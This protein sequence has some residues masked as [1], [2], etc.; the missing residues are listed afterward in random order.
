MKKKL[1]RL[2]CALLV[3]TMVLAM[4]P[5]VSAADKE[6]DKTVTLLSTFDVSISGCTSRSHTDSK[7]PAKDYTYTIDGVAYDD[8][9]VAKTDYLKRTSV[10]GTKS[11]WKVQAVNT[12]DVSGED[13]VK[14]V[15]TCP[16]CNKTATYNITVKYAAI[17][18]MSIDTTK[19]TLTVTKGK[20]ELPKGVSK[21]VKIKLLDAASRGSED[22]VNPT[23]YWISTNPGAV[24]V[25][26]DEKGGT[27]SQTA[28]LTVAEDAEAGSVSTIIATAAGDESKSVSFE[29]TVTDN[30][31]TLTLDK[32]ELSLDIGKTTKVGY[33]MGGPAKTSSCYVVWRYV[34]PDD[35]KEK[36]QDN[37]T[38]SILTLDNT[39]N[40]AVPNGKTDGSFTTKKNGTFYLLAQAFTP[41]REMHSNVQFCRV[42][43]RDGSYSVEIK[44]TKALPTGGSTSQWG[45]NAN[46]SAG[47]YNPD[48]EN[49]KFY[50]AEEYK[51]KDRLTL[52]TWLMSDSASA[53][54]KINATW[55]V[56]DSDVVAF[57]NYD[58]AIRTKTVSKVKDTDTVTIRAMG[59][60]KTTVKAET[61]EGTATFTIEVWDKTMILVPGTT[62]YDYT[63]ELT[64]SSENPIASMQSK[65]PTHPVTE[66][67][68]SGTRVISVPVE[69]FS[70]EID[71]KK[72]TVTFTGELKLEKNENY[73]VYQVV[74]NR[75]NVVTN[76]NVTVKAITKISDNASSIKIKTQPKS[77]TYKVG[78]TISDLKIVAEGGSSLTYQWYDGDTNKAISGATKSTY[79]PSINKSGTYK[80]YC[81]VSS[82]SEYV[83]SETATIK[84]SGEY[85][86]VLSNSSDKTVS[87]P[88][89]N[90]GSGT[91]Y[92]VDVQKWD[93]DSGKYGSAGSCSVSWAVSKN[94]ELG[95]V[96]S[97]SSSVTF[98]GKLAKAATKGFATMTVTATIKKSGT[99]VGTDEIEVTINPAEAATVKQSVGSGAALKSSSITSAV[100][101]AAG[102][103]AKI[104][105]VVFG[106]PKGCKL[107]KSSSSSTSIGDTKCYVSTTSGQKLSDVYVKTTASSASVTYT[108]YD[109]DDYALASGTVSFDANDSNDTISSSGASFKNAAAVDQIIEEYPEAEYVKLDLPRA[110]EGKLYY[111]F[112]TI[113]DFASEVKDSDK[114]YVNASSSQADVEDVYFLPVYGVKGKITI[115]YT[116]YGS[117][118]S[119]LGTGKITL[120]V[121]SKTASSKFTDVTAS[122][123]GSWA[124]D[125]IDFCADN[126]L[127]NGKST[128]SFAPKD[129]LTRGQLVAIL[130]RAAG[131]PSVT[132]T[133]NPFNDVKTG[134]YYYNAVLW[135][136]KNDV[137]NG[138]GAGKFSPNANVTREQIAAILY[139]YMGSP[140][141]T[142]SL[143]GYS[144]RS[145]I[146]S[147]ATTAMQ[148]AIGKGYITGTSS[149]T[150]DPLGQ[151]TRAQ[152][153]VMLHRFLTK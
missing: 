134:D 106:S 102:S 47:V 136:Y 95:S 89:A 119:D 148:W 3:M 152:A 31:L 2:L 43:V 88:S 96:S 74:D 32:E 111:D 122:N 109:A 147:W 77:E 49:D 38:A 10:R 44:P 30:N 83:V 62:P 46:A 6:I 150:L 61:A 149:T 69:W 45:Q 140:A 103:G 35:F 73:S 91:T 36:V 68:T 121:K 20:A 101:R 1:S 66:W 145:K 67:R 141:A 124:A 59:K 113:S 97:T 60:G 5:A 99:E 8:T 84:V 82:G 129:N 40:V 130:Y 12:D 55:T 112:N 100:T 131:S 105:Y 28:T 125:S 139:R 39:T 76:P 16:I 80:Y 120:S 17:K 108:A 34:T 104:S 24:K 94:S 87:T 42:Y 137:V 71:S 52:T 19:S 65:K 90:V 133:T 18:S 4:V 116:A 86:V 57:E 126:D 13:T 143:S 144:D 81:I 75:G 51:D 23:V 142:G 78:K 53:Q 85:R 117:N 115:D 63:G 33:T 25:D 54:D 29:V 26:Y 22:T 92:G 56:E 146:S 98:T 93:Y 114:Y 70:R 128:Y 64:V 11:T 79:K 37:L 123:V 127:V 50:T 151:A 15:A 7:N 107:T 14:L 118:N 72:E 27:A 110:S 48:N 132:G 58:S 9:T 41:S 135:A 138:T 21:T 153:A